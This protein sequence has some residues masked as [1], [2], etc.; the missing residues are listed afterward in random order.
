MDKIFFEIVNN[1]I[2]ASFLIVAIII[3]RIIL[4]RAPKW[5]ICLLW[6]MVGIRLVMPFEIESRLSLLPDI[7]L[8]QVERSH[9]RLTE[10]LEL[11]QKDEEQEL[12]IQNHQNSYQNE[13]QQIVQENQDDLDIAENGKE[14]VDKIFSISRIQVAFCVWLLGSLVLLFFAVLSFLKLKQKIATSIHL[15]DNIYLCDDIESPFVMGILKP[16]IYLTSKIPGEAWDSILKHEYAHIKR[17]DHIWKLLGYALLAIYWFNP[18]SWI[19][20]ILFCKDMELACDEKATK[21]MDKN[22]RA[23][24]CEALITCSI[25]HKKVDVCPVAFGEVGVKERIKQILNYKKPTLWMIFCAGIVCGI[26]AVCF[27]TNPESKKENDEMFFENMDGVSESSSNRQE[28]T[29]IVT[30]YDH[31][32]PDEQGYR[33]LT[34]ERDVYVYEFEDLDKN[35]IEE[36]AKVYQIDTEQEYICRYIFYWN[37]EAIY[38]YENS[39]GMSPGEAEYQDLDRDG[40]REIFLTFWPHVNSMPLMEYIVLKQNK[41]MS[42]KTLEIIHGEEIYNNAFPISIAKGKNE[43]EAV[44]SCEG[45]EKTVSFDIAY[46][47]A[48][49]LEL[50]GAVSGEE[51][52]YLTK[53]INDYKYGFPETSEWYS[54]GTVCAWGIWNIKS[55]E[56]Q[57]QPC[58]IATHGIQGYDKFDF[59]G[60]LDVYF[61]Y[62]AQGKTRFLDMRFRNSESWAGTT[63]QAKTEFTMEDLIALCDAGSETLKNAMTDFSE[64]GELSYSNLEK[65]ISEYSL[66]WDYFCTLPYE[67]KEYRLQV[68]YWKPEEAE[69]YGHIANELDGI[70]ISYPEVEDMQLLYTVEERYTPNLDIRSF[71]D[72]KY[73]LEIYVDLDLPDELKFGNYKMDLILGQ[74]CLFEGDYEEQPHGEGT[75]E[76][77]YASGGIEFIKKEYFPG[78]VR[79]KDGKL[80]EVSVLMNH[81]GIDSD[82]EFIE[83]CDMQAV[84]CEYFCDLFTAAEAEKYMQEHGIAYEDF[85]WNSK[86]W[87]VFF[88]EE[89]SKYVYMLFLNQEYF[90][91]EDIVKLAQSVKFKVR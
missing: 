61:D 38:E 44:I 85:T 64:G 86:Y 53:L 31:I 56:Y 48:K 66:T 29:D 42:W 39:Y 57:G 25:S 10:P 37:G 84:L 83:G 21:G 24:Y 13:N 45:L 16:C 1:S 72:K 77:W 19:A 62:D 17:A 79:F 18:L 22:Q 11:K 33:W 63:R 2:T 43:W 41:D 54:F 50:R 46:Y 68:S 4:K 82:F 59:W 71:L 35:G 26:V 8:L 15:H 69:E 47:H 90:D 20:Y 74:G 65:N 75:P 70:W 78:E 76:D 40:E 88:A 9:D 58:L 30:E 3:L 34:E 91:K 12:Y 89:D 7:N 67:E 51:W 52:D 60:E 23:G 87:Y 32:E 81:S 36:Y 28:E 73:D 49:L 6:A 27:M 55:G 80:T 14:T 5:S